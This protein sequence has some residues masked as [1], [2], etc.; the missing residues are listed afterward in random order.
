MDALIKIQGTVT[1]KADKSPLKAVKVIARQE[2]AELQQETDQDGAYTLNLLPGLWRISVQAGGYK[3]AEAYLYNFKADAAG[4][5]FSLEEGYTVS[6]VI[7]TGENGKPAA[8][9]VVEAAAKI[10]DKKLSRQA[11]SDAGGRYRFSGL[12]G[13]EWTL[14]GQRGDGYTEREKIELGPDKTNLTLTLSHAMTRQDWQWGTGFFAALCALLIALAAIYLWAH[15]RYASPPESELG[16]FAGQIDQAVQ[17]TAEA[18]KDDKKVEKILPTLVNSIETLKESWTN[19]SGQIAALTGGQGKQIELFISKAKIAAS[20]KNLQEIQLALASLSAV[21]KNQRPLFFWTQPPLSY[22]EV[23]FW[24]LAGSL[25]SLLIT[26]GYYLRRKRFYAEGIW[27]HASHLLSVP[28]MSLV[29]VFLI[30]QLKLTVQIDATKVD[31]DI[32]SPQLLAAISFIIAV[33]PWAM[34]DFVKETGA[35]VFSQIQRQLG[36]DDQ[37]PTPPANPPATP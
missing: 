31:L 34:L 37:P 26:C 19:I 3:E 4:I 14:R 7:L 22:L 33:R 35:Q 1:K 10:D 13:G 17:L 20:A 15:Q 2:G 29:V 11:L 8:G 16:V 36:G 21:V 28:L 12:P 32:R 23:L 24:S 6:G 25:A 30:S 27:M 9:V 18:L 5:D